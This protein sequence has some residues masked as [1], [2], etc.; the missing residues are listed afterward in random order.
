VWIDYDAAV[1]MHRVRPVVAAE[2]RLERLASSTPEDNRITYGC[3]N[4]PVDFF[5]R[6]IAPVLG[7]RAGLAYVLPEVLTLDEVFMRAPDRLAPHPPLS[8]VSS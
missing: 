1:S 3:I 2:R 5:D 7:H 6:R 4:V 8:R